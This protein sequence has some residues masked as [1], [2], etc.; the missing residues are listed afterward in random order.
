[1][2]DDTNAPGQSDI[3]AIAR[4]MFDAVAPGDSPSMARV[5]AWVGT[6][7]AG[8]T[9]YGNEWALWPMD[10]C[11]IERDTLRTW[12][13]AVG[14]PGGAWAVGETAGGRI[15][16]LEWGDCWRG[17]RR[18][19]PGDVDWAG[20]VIAVIDTGAKSMTKTAMIECPSCG[21]NG[22]MG[23]YCEDCECTGL[24]SVPVNVAEHLAWLEKH[25]TAET[26]RAE[27]AEAKLRTEQESLMDVARENGHNIVNAEDCRRET[28]VYRVL[29][30]GAVAAAYTGA[31]DS[32][33]S[34]PDAETFANN[35]LITLLNVA[36]WSG[37]FDETDCTTGDIRRVARQLRVRPDL[38]EE[39]Q[40]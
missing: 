40:P 25:A 16:R 7:H 38:S 39:A 20:T 30:T 6:C 36:L 28:M 9:R 12:A 15:A 34:A 24:V 21:G 33:R 3:Y 23:V 29:L 5:G 11:R 22:G 37:A 27:Q 8:L 19:W 32:L 1:V 26:Q 2:S 31:H 13:A 18:G 4:Q 10:V 35:Y 17:A 14:Q